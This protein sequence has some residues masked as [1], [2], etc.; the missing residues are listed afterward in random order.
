MYFWLPFTLMVLTAIFS[1]LVTWW[2][3]SQALNSQKKEIAGHVSRYGRIR[4]EF[5]LF[6]D[7][8]GLLNGNYQILQSE[9]TRL[10]SE[11]KKWKA[12][13][14]DRE[15][16]LYNLDRKYTTLYSSHDITLNE[17]EKLRMEIL[18]HKRLHTQQTN[19]VLNIQD[20]FTKITGID[21]K[22]L[23]LLYAHHIFTFCKLSRTTKE[24][25][26]DILEK[27]GKEFNGV[28]PASWPE[29]AGMAAQESF[30]E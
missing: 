19:R 27:G 14:Q 28:E 9:T 6:Q 22:V 2:W 20:D 1:A 11:V 17:I 26:F 21:Q 15:G 3:R 16:A 13:H 5:D 24:E 18:H 4:S 12:K 10:K 7:Q 29:Q 30:I 8:Y 23:E 25:L